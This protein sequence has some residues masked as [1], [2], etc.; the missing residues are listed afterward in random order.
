MQ[1]LS[2]EREELEELVRHLDWEKRGSF[3]DDGSTAEGEHGEGQGDGLG[4]IERR[5]EE[6]EWL[7]SLRRREEG[8]E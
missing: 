8:R 4:E 1:Q 5:A 6:D 7:Q 2:Q 3:L